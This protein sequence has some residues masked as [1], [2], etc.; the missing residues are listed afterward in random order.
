MSNFLNNCIVQLFDHIEAKCGIKLVTFTDKDLQGQQ[1]QGSDKQGYMVDYNNKGNGTVYKYLYDP[2][3][4]FNFRFHQYLAD[5]NFVYH[6]K[7]WV[8]LMFSTGAVKPLTYVLSHK[9]EGIQYVTKPDADD[10][11]G[12]DI[13]P[14]KTRRVSVPMQIAIVSNNIS[15]LYENLEKMA[16]YFDRFIN[17]PYNQTIRYDGKN[18]MQWQCIGQCTNITQSEVS[19]LDTETRGT[20]VTATFNFN[21]IHWITDAP[22]TPLHLL[23]KIILEVRD[24]SVDGPLITT[25]IIE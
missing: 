24:G 14:Y 22:E 25:E 12:E 17:F 7:P 5:I 1:G 4:S 2:G 23:E 8:T 21:L 19:K 6:N 3:L 9:Y 13:V 15:Y 20:I 16:S 10:N 11:T 18:V